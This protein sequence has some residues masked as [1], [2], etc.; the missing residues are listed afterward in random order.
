MKSPMSVC[1]ENVPGFSVA[2]Q[3]ERSVQRLVTW[4]RDSPLIIEI[5]LQYIQYSSS[6]S[7]SALAKNDKI[8]MPMLGRYVYH[9]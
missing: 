8:S 2:F 7:N 5:Y 1:S 9:V 6:S 4:R 3:N